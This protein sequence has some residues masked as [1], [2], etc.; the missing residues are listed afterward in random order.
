MKYIL[1]D[2]EGTTTSISFVHDILFP[3]SKDRIASY[4]KLHRNEETIKDILVETKKTVAE[5]KKIQIDDEQSIAQL[6]EWIRIDRKHPSLK[7]IQGLIWS[8][9]YNSGE[10]KGHVYQDVPV[11][12][13]KWKNANISLG[14]Y[15][16]GSVEAQKV[17][18]G[19][20]IY[21]DLN[22]FISNNFD[23]SI[24]HKRD[25]N[26]YLN[27]SKEL[28]LDPKE[29]LFLSDISEELDAAK[30]AGLKTIQLV[31]LEDVPYTGHDQV[32]TFED[33]RF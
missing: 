5:E 7:K 9:G 13:E 31:R 18:F 22:H 19:Y 28:K 32:K 12:L 2:I 27:I 29:I 33:I 30:K 26:S 8:E 1:M 11:A 24:G 20:S 6:I 21:G 23:T 10:L 4:I 16:S 3:Y 25:E 14:I 17:L 15:S